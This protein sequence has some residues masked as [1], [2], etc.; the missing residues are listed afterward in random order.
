MSS[1]HPGRPKRTES[2]PACKTSGC[3]KTTEGGALGF[4]HSHYVAARRG[5]YDK[6]TGAPL[7]EPLRVSSYGP[8]ARCS[9]D[10]CG[11]RPKG[12]GLCSL[13]WQRAQKGISLEAPIRRR[14]PRQEI[15]A[16]CKMVGCDLRPTSR[17][18]CGTHA[19]Q[20]RRGI[21]DDQGNKLRE[22]SKG[23]RPR[24]KDKWVGQQGYVLVECPLEFE[25]MARQDGTILEHRLVMAQHL[26]RPLEEWEIVHHKYGLRTDNRIQNLELLDGRA[27]SGMEGHPPGH[28]FDSASAAQVLLQDASIPE[29]VK[30]S[31]KKLF[32]R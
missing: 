3:V 24:T 20:R 4:C 28:A 22:P 16:E 6:K 8:G 31:L 21:L 19:E 14:L 29:K 26:G 15:V 25:S 2:W 27:G 30:A 13:H 23:G 9:V 17:G 10:G 5:Q 1:R 32:K 18:L 12:E 11:N 7:R